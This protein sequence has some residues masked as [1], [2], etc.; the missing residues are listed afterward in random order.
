MTPPKSKRA[1]RLFG[2]AQDAAAVR[3]YQTH[4][5]VAALAIERWR[6]NANLLIWVGVLF[7]LCWTVPHV[8]GFVAGGAP[9]WSTRWVTAWAVEPSIAAP[10]IGILWAEQVAGRYGIKLAGWPRF[11]KWAC[12]V[13]TYAMNTWEY[14]AQVEPRGVLIHSVPPL[15]VFLCAEVLPI[16][17]ERMTESVWAAHADARKRRRSDTAAGDAGEDGDTTG[18]TP[19]VSVAPVAQEG[20]TPPVAAAVSD[21]ARR[22]VAPHPAALAPGDTTESD[23]DA[24]T[25]A[26]PSTEGAPSPEAAGGDTTRAGEA[27]GDTAQV[28]ADVAPDVA[29]DDPGASA[30]TAPGDADSDSDVA[31]LPVASLSDKAA[32]DE[33]VVAW[34]VADPDM[35]GAEIGRRLGKTSR[36]GQRVKDR[37][38]PVAAARRAEGGVSGVAD[39]GDSDV[40]LPDGSRARVKRWKT[41]S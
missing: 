2:A 30:D 41:S 39:G 25:A 31:A 5:D 18:P 37:L 19:Q 14:W 21:G 35:S 26:T 34:L 40:V 23:A 28:G 15:L 20:A 17:R 13:A 11:T 22:D 36:T 27:T 3:G 9:E 29:D 16:V 4:P 1:T 33:Q 7:G 6:R 10:L 12:L 38:S 32:R 8:Q 24:R